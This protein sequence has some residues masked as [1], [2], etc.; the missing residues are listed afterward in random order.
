MAPTLVGHGQFKDWEEEDDLIYQ[1]VNY[2][3]V[4]RTAQ[5]TLGL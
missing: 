5:A 4:C 3:G 2:E 1:S